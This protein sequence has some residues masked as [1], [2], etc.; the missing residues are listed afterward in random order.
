MLHVIIPFSSFLPV[1]SPSLLSL[2]HSHSIGMK[3][4]SAYGG[5]TAVTSNVA[6]ATPD[7]EYETINN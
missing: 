5:V 4:C 6:P 1:A 3:E 2:H 7:A